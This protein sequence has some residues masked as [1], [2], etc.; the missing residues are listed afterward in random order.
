[1]PKKILQ[2]ILFTVLAFV[3]SMAIASPLTG[4]QATFTFNTSGRQV[5][6]LVGVGDEFVFY[7]F[8][9]DLDAGAGNQFLFSST[10]DAGSFGGNSSITISGLHFTDGSILT[11]FQLISTNLSD[12]FFTTTGDSLT[13]EYSNWL[14]PAGTVI[15]GIYLTKAGDKNVVSEPSSLALLGIGLVTIVGLSRRRLS[16]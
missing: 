13:F 6:S 10:P 4:T 5:T 16:K 12:L 7:N 3:G 1:M 2:A 11:G 9:I 14:A 8:H 15:S